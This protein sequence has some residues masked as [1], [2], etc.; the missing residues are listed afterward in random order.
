MKSITPKFTIDWYIKWVSSILLL[1]AMSM[2]GVDELSDYDLYLSLI[3]VFGWL[4][5]GILWKDRALILLNGIGFAILL[6]T[7]IQKLYGV[8]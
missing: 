1:F 4:V 3:G 2:R 5:I 8:I 6:N 7:F